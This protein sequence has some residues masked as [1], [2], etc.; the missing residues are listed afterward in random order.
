[1][2]VG[3]AMTTNE[4]RSSEQRVEA[5]DQR[6]KG[7][8]KGLHLEIEPKAQEIELKAAQFCENLKKLD[9]LE[10]TL[11]KSINQL[12]EFDLIETK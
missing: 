7:M 4:E 10:S 1:M 5:F 8:E 3:E 11:Q 2:A 6:I 12:S 9:Q